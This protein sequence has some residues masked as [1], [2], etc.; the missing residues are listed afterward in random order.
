MLG[1]QVT[2]KQTGHDHLFLEPQDSNK[3]T[4]HLDTLC[5]PSV[6]IM[7]L[8]SNVLQEDDICVSY[9]RI[10]VLMSL[11]IVTMNV[12]TVTVMSPQLVHANNCDLL[13]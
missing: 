4:T 12:W 8:R 10:H 13:P 3:E 5:F 6:A 1:S 7:A 11:I 2:N 9:M